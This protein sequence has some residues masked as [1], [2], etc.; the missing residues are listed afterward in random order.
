M[1]TEYYVLMITANIPDSGNRYLRGPYFSER[2]L[3]VD[4]VVNTDEL[5]AYVTGACS[6]FCF[7][8]LRCKLQCIDRY[9]SAD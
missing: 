7:V 5:Q 6:V 8:R 3:F 1:F 4:S 9:Q 2:F